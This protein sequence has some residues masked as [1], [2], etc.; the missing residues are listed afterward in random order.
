MLETDCFVFRVWSGET[1]IFLDP[2]KCVFCIFCGDGVFDTFR[3][4]FV[5]GDPLV[6]VCCT[7]VYA[8]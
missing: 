4:T 1:D 7:V 5:T 6:F 2:K 3:F 8:S